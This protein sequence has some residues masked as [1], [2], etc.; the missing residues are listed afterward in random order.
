MLSGAVAFYWQKCYNPLLIL[1]FR[2]LKGSLYPTAPPFR[3][4]KKLQEF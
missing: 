1:D 4:G 3:Y 2:D